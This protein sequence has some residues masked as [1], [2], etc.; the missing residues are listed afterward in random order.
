[1]RFEGDAASLAR[2]RV[3]WRRAN[4][5]HALSF[6]LLCLVSMALL[7]AIT[8]A[9]LGSGGEV[10]AGFG[11]VRDQGAALEARFGAPWR[12]VYHA[13]G[14][15]VLLSTELALLDASARV[16]ASLVRAS[17]AR[18]LPG[19]TR[20]RVYFVVLWS[21]IGFGALVL[22]ADFDQPLA[23]LVLSGALN[24]FVMFLC[25]GLLLWL[26]LRSFGPPLRPSP[27]RV[28]ALLAALAFY[29]FFG[30]VTL[31]EELGRLAG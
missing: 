5:E 2:W 16:V 20:A 27:L 26:G 3:W 1:V 23:L 14:I 17:T 31:R 6:W 24:A 21:L 8:H 15:A 13:G 10:A 18:V 4:V 11:F 25:A 12:V 30:F 22:L 9:L 29:G 7:C 28:A 19:L